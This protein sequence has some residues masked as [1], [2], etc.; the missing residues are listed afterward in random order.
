MKHVSFADKSLFMGDDAADTLLE[1]ARLVADNERA[2]TVTL[3]SISTDGNTVE[4]SFLLDAS[5]ILMVETTNSEIDAPD[6]SEAVQDMKERIDAITRPVSVD[7][8]EPPYVDYDL[9]DSF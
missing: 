2:D 6:N 5:T 7:S 3:R 4:A 1:Y 9:P 8:Q